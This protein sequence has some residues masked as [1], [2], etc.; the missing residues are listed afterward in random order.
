MGNFKLRLVDAL[1]LFCQCRP[2]HVIAG[3]AHQSWVYNPYAAGSIFQ[4]EAGI[5]EEMPFANCIGNTGRVE[6]HK[7]VVLDSWLKRFKE[8]DRNTSPSRQSLLSI[9]PEFKDLTFHD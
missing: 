2:Q 5:P 7:K 6:V 4:D 1:R 8:I 3:E 9:F